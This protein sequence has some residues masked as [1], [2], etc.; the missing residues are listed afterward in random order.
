[1][2]PHGP[3]LQLLATQN[4]FVVS[5]EYRFEWPQQFEDCLAALRWV[6]SEEEAVK[7][8]DPHRITLCGASAGGH[9]AAIVALQALREK[10]CPSGIHSIV[11]FYPAIDL[12]DLTKAT[13]SLPLD[14]PFVH[15][16]NRRSLLTIFFEMVVLKCRGDLWCK[17]EPLRELK[18]RHELAQLWPPTLIVHGERDSVVPIEASYEF[19]RFL[20]AASDEKH[21]SR[22]A[23]DGFLRVPGGRHSFEIPDSKEAELVFRS[24]AA[25]LSLRDTDVV[26][27][28][29]GATP[30]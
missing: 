3:L 25:W 18:E 8:A 22:R 5:A 4:W 14:C 9:I 27:Q 7:G 20:A 10:I 28:Q 1:M 17:A 12:G 26:G 29:I 15:H 2:N 23:C 30:T 6:C 16:K 19:L 11:L 24:V 21:Y 13:A